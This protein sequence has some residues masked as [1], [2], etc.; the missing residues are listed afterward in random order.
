[1]A[2]DDPLETQRGAVPA[3]TAE[4]SADGFADGY[5]IGHGGFG[6]VYHCVQTA[7]DRTVA[8]KVLTAD[9]DEENRARFFREQRAMGL[10]TGHPNIITVLQVGATASGRP[11]IVM[12][13]CPQDSLDVRIR[14]RGAVGL[15]ATL[16][17]GVK[18]AGALETAHRLGI[19]HRDVKPGNILLTD[20]G[21][22]ALTDFG[23]AH[24][25]GGFETATGTVTGSP[26][27]TSPEVL[28]GEPPSP[29]SDVYSL[30]ATLFCAVTGHAAFERRT[31][32]QVV[33]QFLR[34]TTNPTPDLRG[35]GIPGDLSAVIE[36]SMSADP[37]DRPAA[38]AELGDALRQVQLHHG[39]PADEMALHVEPG[40]AQRGWAYPRDSAGTTESAFGSSPASPADAREHSAQADAPASA[41]VVPASRGKDGN[42]LH[43]LTSF[44]GRRRELSEA[45]KLLSV[46]RLVTL[47]GIGGVG[48]TRLA[49]RVGADMRRGFA[50]G[51]WLVDLG[52]LGD[53]S[54]L[55][56]V[57]AGALGLRDQSARPA[58]DV[59]LEYLAPRHLLLVLDNCEQ[60]VDAVAALT[61]ALLRTCPD[62]RILTTSRE[63]LA[64][65]GEVTL[66]V[67]PL[68]VPE[69]DHQPTLQG[70]PRYDAVTLFAERA[71]AAVPTFAL[72]EDNRT[73]VTRICQQLEGL[74]LPIELAAARLRAMSAAQILAHL[75][76]RYRLLSVGARG[77]PSRQQ[78][79][80]LC[81]DWSHGLCTPREQQAW[82]RLSVF[83]GGFELD[84]V[85]GTYA[86]ELNE[87]D[88]LDV[89]ASLVDKSILIREEPGTVV[90]YRL[91]ETLRDYGREKLL[92]SDE[93]A[94]IRRRHRDWYQQLV[95]RAESEWISDRQLGWIARLE[96]ERPN[97]RDALAFCAT[98][99]TESEAGLRIAGALYPFWFSRGLLSE[100]RGALERALNSS[101]G[102][103][104]VDRVKALY[105]AS[106]LAGR[107]GDLDAGTALIDEGRRMVEQLGD[108]H[109]RAL[110]RSAEGHLALFSGEL[111]RAITCLTDALEHFHTGD[112]L[113]LQIE[114]QTVLALANVLRGDTQPA[115]DCYERTI[116]ITQSRGEFVYRAY[117]HWEMALAVWRQGDL[118]RAT[119]LLEQGL[120][121]TRRVDD[122]LA[123]AWCLEILAWI[124]AGDNRAQRAGVLLGAADAL[125]RTVGSPTV[126][127][128]HTRGF[129]DEC[130][131][132]SRRALGPRAFDA[133]RSD[134]QSLGFDGAIAYALGE[135]S[136]DAK[137]SSEPA[138]PLTKR[139]QQVANLVAQGLTNKAVATKLVIS[140]RTAQGHVE[141][142]LTKLGFTSRAQIAAWVVE[143][144]QRP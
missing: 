66:R 129:H 107:Q 95:L 7:L 109:A 136:Q 137:P 31:G 115:I 134:G 100:G 117:S 74:P 59:V 62:L 49:L 64:V 132:R 63:T 17:L 52:G 41:R 118:N 10:L 142:I 47:T 51:V 108:P 19:L 27:F 46:S 113:F 11:Y 29:V 30:G 93:F 35:R 4:L 139:E 106:V 81:M 96:R 14:N 20:Y 127:V 89:V 69:E 58:Q 126:I 32:E 38:A 141:H 133:A 22:P 65:G 130:E 53:G 135:Q 121:L 67:P 42:L 87:S 9:L 12:P 84:A 122:P 54:L 50:D 26:A 73:T 25:A 71:V 21:E 18:M 131:Q 8:V 70:L 6:V 98:E 55:P 33:A 28:K 16:R 15:D 75:T 144:E 78:T 85:E 94:I 138:S 104:S 34:I 45:K 143:H 24:V 101:N 92:A 79:L 102:P 103:P 72:T 13:Y 88:V 80:R 37:R 2:T 140:Q 82:A 77:A 23:I 91:L 83:A 60:I 48:K 86:G 57:V 1:M 111:P 68:T 112:D 43:E 120:H 76:D 128:H 5:E 114:N 36:R 110:I 125:R 123:T 97:L 99:F 44:V 105:T 39:F 124:A 61:E 90:R 3:V 116:E 119:R 56:G 40:Q